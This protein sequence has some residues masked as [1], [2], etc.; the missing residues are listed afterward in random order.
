M[1]LYKQCI[2]LQSNCLILI[3]VIKIIKIYFL[4]TIESNAWIISKK[5]HKNVK[6]KYSLNF[7]IGFNSC[8]II[9]EKIKASEFGP[10]KNKSPQ[11]VS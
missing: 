11:L 6:L 10:L 2:Y 9:T 1:K 8:K 7:K 4:D 5:I 3:I